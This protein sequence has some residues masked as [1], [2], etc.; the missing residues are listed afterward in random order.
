[1]Y[2]SEHSGFAPE[3]ANRVAFVEPEVYCVG[4]W[5]DRGL[6]HHTAYFYRVCAVDRQGRRGPMSEEFSGV[7]KE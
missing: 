6:K 5:I 3:E 7:T 4:R 1:M 2:R